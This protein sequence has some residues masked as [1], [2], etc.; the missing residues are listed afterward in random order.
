M[1]S[2]ASPNDMID[3]YDTRVLG[4][5]VKD[6]GTREAVANL[7]VNNRLDKALKVGTGRMKAALRRAKRYTVADINALAGETLEFRKDI[8]CSLAFWFLWRSKP[9][10]EH[11]SE[12]QRAARED[13]EA[14]LEMLKSGE[15]IFE[16]VTA[17]EDAGIPEVTGV[18][19]DEND[20]NWHLQR[21]RLTG[22]L[23]PRRR[24]YQNR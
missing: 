3:R 23:Y 10:T 12:A 1:S 19:R 21:N 11:S 15:E 17:T 16:G 6:D 5:L 9:W 2:W 18:T 4:Q 7:D 8:C 22:H 24:T 14:Y 20:A 13:A